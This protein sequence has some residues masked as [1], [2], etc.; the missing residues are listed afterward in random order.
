[1]P[2]PPAHVSPRF[3]FFCL[4]GT[5]TT[6]SSGTPFATTRAADLLPLRYD[7]RAVA[8]KDLLCG[9]GSNE[10]CA[11]ENITVCWSLGGYVVLPRSYL[12]LGCGSIV[13][14]PG[15]ERRDAYFHVPVCRSWRGKLM[16]HIFVFQAVFFVCL[17][18]LLS[19]SSVCQAG[20]NSHA[21]VPEIVFAQHPVHIPR[22]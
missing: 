19:Y 13:S 18:P 10:V 5:T 8:S 14:C 16:E 17:L 9:G 6:A 22:I 15:R 21:C 3:H 4:Q 20:Y 7:G 12:F 1:M 2:P 11:D